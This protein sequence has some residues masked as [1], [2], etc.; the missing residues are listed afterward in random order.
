M[1]SA[2]G[3]NYSAVS[4]GPSM[5]HWAEQHRASAEYASD[6]IANTAVAL[7][8]DIAA[9]LK[10]YG[11]DA[12][13]G[14][15]AQFGKGSTADQVAKEIH[16]TM[17]QAADHLDAAAKLVKAADKLFQQNVAIPVDMVK[18]ARETGAKTGAL[19]M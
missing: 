7:V 12:P 10:L 11:L 14:W 6:N 18:K 2:S 5:A 15:L 16:K 17:R 19:N 8:P 1:A 13:T 4:D 9:V 3:I